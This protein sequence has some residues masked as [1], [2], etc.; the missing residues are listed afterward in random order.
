[1][2]AQPMQLQNS[3]TARRG[4][5]INSHADDDAVHAFFFELPA[6]RSSVPTAAVASVGCSIGVEGLG[7]V[8]G[9]GVGVGSQ[10]RES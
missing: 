2:A 4:R 8:V 3:N 10:L 7:D 1:M 5:A 9:E 6:P